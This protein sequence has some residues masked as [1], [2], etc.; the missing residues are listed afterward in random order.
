LEHSIDLLRDGLKRAPDSIVLLLCS[1][2]IHAQAM[3]LVNALELYK[4]A[5]LRDPLQPLSFIN[6]ARSFQQLGRHSTAMQHL[7]KAIEM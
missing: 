5:Y 7:H 6:A 1:G 2:D 4:E 3:D